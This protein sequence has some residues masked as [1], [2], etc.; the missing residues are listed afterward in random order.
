MMMFIEHEFRIHYN[1]KI[2]IVDCGFTDR[3]EWHFQ[4]MHGPTDSM[5][6]IEVKI[7][8]YYSPRKKVLTLIR[9]GVPKE[10][11]RK[12]LPL[13]ERES[14]NLCNIV[15]KALDYVTFK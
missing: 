12:V 5:A 3:G 9:K 1:R 7:N 8:A 4:V 13:T 15:I 2:E 6:V 10:E 14:A 11:R